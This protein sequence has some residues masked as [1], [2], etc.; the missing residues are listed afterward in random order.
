MKIAEEGMSAAGSL[1]VVVA[2]ASEG[3]SR[4]KSWPFVTLSAFE[5][6]AAIVMKLSGAIFIGIAPV[7]SAELRELWET[8]SNFDDDAKWYQEGRAYQKHLGID[9]VDSRPQVQSN[10]PDLL[11]ETGI[12]NFNYDYHRNS[13]SR[14]VISPKSEWY[15]PIWQVRKIL[16]QIKIITTMLIIVN[17]GEA[18]LNVGLV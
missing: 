9:D 4:E 14:A 8:Y 18:L 13:T 5:E 12:A 17:F 1:V 15:L 2:V 3:L 11:L 7:V 6:R 16:K 10:D